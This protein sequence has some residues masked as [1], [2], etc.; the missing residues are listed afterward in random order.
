MTQVRETMGE[1]AFAIV[2]V[3][4]RALGN[5]TS[6]HAWLENLRETQRCPNRW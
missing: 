6:L 5:Q 1:S 2:K 3:E 4:N